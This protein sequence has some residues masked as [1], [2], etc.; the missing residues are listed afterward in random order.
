MATVGTED[1]SLLFQFNSPIDKGIPTF[2]NDH[3]INVTKSDVCSL[4]TCN[5]E[6]DQCTLIRSDSSFGVPKSENTSSSSFKSKLSSNFRRL[7]PTKFHP[8]TNTRSLL[9]DTKI[10]SQYNNYLNQKFSDNAEEEESEHDRLLLSRKLKLE[11]MVDRFWLKDGE[12]DES[13]FDDSSD[14]E[15]IEGKTV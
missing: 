8:T 5:E 1:S 14:E 10:F 2:L 6:E 12:I 9:S 7:N 4:D 3:A 13:I 15:E 11:E